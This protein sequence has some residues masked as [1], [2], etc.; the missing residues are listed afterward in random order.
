MSELTR[1]QSGIISI[2]KASA[3]V[4]LYVVHYY[5]LSLQSSSQR[6]QS[7]AA[8]NDGERKPRFFILLAPSSHRRRVL[9][10]EVS[11]ATLEVVQGATYKGRSSFA[12]LAS[13]L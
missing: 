5:S 6:R 13:R 2:R 11:F 1:T 3:S 9:G 8:N 10:K 7:S 4:S 12:K